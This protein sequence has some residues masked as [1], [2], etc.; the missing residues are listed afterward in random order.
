MRLKTKKLHELLKLYTESAKSGTIRLASVSN[1]NGNEFIPIKF[2][3]ANSCFFVPFLE[4]N[5]K[6]KPGEEF[7]HGGVGMDD[8]L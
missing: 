8:A 4:E 3:Y 2:N 7:V 6:R 1:N 5:V